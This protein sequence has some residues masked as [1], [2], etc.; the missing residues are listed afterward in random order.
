[1]YQARV[2]NVVLPDESTVPPAVDAAMWKLFVAI[3]D[4]WKLGDDPKPYRLRLRA[5]MSN[6]IR[7]SPI[8]RDFYVLARTVID[9]LIA[10]TGDRAKAYELLFTQKPR[11]ATTTPPQTQLEF[12]QQYVANEFIGLRLSL[13][14]FKA[15]GAINYCGYFGAPILKVSPCRI[16]RRSKTNDGRYP[17]YRFGRCGGRHF[18]A[19]A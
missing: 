16:A 9:E 8:Y 14:S 17:H 1:M 11:V 13:G 2:N 3:G 7:F 18:A 10:Q 12:V 19:P 5:F 4:F 15:F 6:R